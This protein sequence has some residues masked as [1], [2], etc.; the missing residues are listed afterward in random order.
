VV[1]CLLLLPPPSPLHVPQQELTHLSSLLLH[2][3]FVVHFFK[4]YSSVLSSWDDTKGHQFQRHPTAFE[5][6][7]LGVSLSV[8]LSAVF[9]GDPRWEIVNVKLF[10]FYK[11]YSTFD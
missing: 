9:L 1:L 6:T 2:F 5:D 8:R 10:Y 11:N 4:A 7:P 3:P